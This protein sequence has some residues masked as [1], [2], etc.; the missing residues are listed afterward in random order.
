MGGHYQSGF[1]V[2]CSAD[3]VIKVSR[4]LFGDDMLMFCWADLEQI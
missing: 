3:N 1:I 2:G 4:L